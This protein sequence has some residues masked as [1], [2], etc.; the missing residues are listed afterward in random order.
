M[1]ELLAFLEGKKTYITAILFGV[2]NFGYAM[3]WWALDNEIW[4]AINSLLAMFGL[5]FLRAGIKKK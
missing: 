5:G 4:I 2:F 3:G 1:K